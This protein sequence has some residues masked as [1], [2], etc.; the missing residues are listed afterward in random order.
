MKKK[1]SFI[2]SIIAVVV[3]YGIISYFWD[4]IKMVLIIILGCILVFIFIKLT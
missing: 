4:T 2:S 3:L 1:D